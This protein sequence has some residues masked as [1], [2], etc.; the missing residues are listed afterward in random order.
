[1][2]T[3][4]YYTRAEYMIAKGY[5]PK[6]DVDKLAGIIQQ[7]EAANVISTTFINSRQTVYGQFADEIGRR[8][9]AMPPEKRELLTEFE[10]TGAKSNGNL[11]VVTP[12]TTTT[13]TEVANT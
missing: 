2:S 12:V 6:M 1:M 5:L 8:V 13:P 3:D 4:K 10:R 11:N 9:E 7:I